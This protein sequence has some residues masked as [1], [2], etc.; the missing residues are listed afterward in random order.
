M[1]DKNRQEKK[2]LKAEESV[3]GEAILKNGKSLKFLYWLFGVLFVVVIGVSGYVVYDIKYAFEGEKKEGADIG[4][5]LRE[6]E[7]IQQKLSKANIDS[8]AVD[9]AI[10]EIAQ[11][12]FKLQESEQTF[13][14]FNTAYKQ[15]R[16][17]VLELNSRVKA[18]EEVAVKKEQ[19]QKLSK[20][21]DDIKNNRN[22]YRDGNFILTTAFIQLRQAFIDGRPYEE[23]L[24]MVRKA[25]GDQAQISEL[26]SLIGKYAEEGVS[27][28]LELKGKYEKLIDEVMEAADEAGDTSVGGRIVSKLKSL[29]K[30]R[31][32]EPDEE[33]NSVDAILSRAE[34]AVSNH[35]LKEAALELKKL[36]KESEDLYAIV[37]DWVVMAEVR[38]KGEEK[39]SNI[40]SNLLAKLGE[41]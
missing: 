5:L 41:K 40:T 16:T 7:K 39:I 33:D 32:L 10:S 3:H 24:K 29:V 34:K 2:S 9:E 19:L 20:R 15:L 11:F 38:A 4:L 6:T 8:P 21:V 1:D 31:K 30:V 13:T 27:N 12:R 35:N 36:K 14:D 22:F 37:K 28:Y 17:A 26:L 25:G 18:L 23:E